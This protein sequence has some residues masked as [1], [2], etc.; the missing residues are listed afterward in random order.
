MPQY[1]IIR[2]YRDS[3]TPNRTIKTHLTLEQ[4][5][6]HCQDP[7]T[8]SSTCTGKVAR[9]RTKRL[10]AWFDG[11]SEMPVKQYRRT[12]RALSLARAKHWSF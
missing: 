1:K 4:A 7:E 3:D 5:Q 12:N 9:A 11:Y 6:A 10:G 8:S 2:H